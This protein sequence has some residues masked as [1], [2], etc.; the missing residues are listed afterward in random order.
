MSIRLRHLAAVNPSTP[1]FD[2]LPADADVPFLPLECVWP[3]SLLDTSRRKT[4]AELS[5]GYTRFRQGDILL[6]KITP[7]FQA[8]RTVIAVDIDGGVGAGTTELHVVRVGPE[9]DC[10][11]HPLPALIQAVP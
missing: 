1:E 2:R 5:V 8:D 6:P 3:G 9:A 4:R 10:T 11:V 7:T